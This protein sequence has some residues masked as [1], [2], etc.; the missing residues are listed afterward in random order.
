MPFRIR[1]LDAAVDVD[2]FRCGEPQLDAYIRRYASQDIRRGLT[3]VFVAT[4]EQGPQRLAGFFSLSA[5][6]VSAAILLDAM[7]R[8]LPHYPVP[9]ALLGRLAVDEGFQ[10]QGLGAVL[11]A[12]ACL[13]VAQAS[14]VLAVAGLVV[15]VKS[16]TAAAFYKHF[17]FVALPGDPGRLLLPSKAFP[18]GI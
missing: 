18:A 14:A 3:R 12:D 8:K 10:G 13:K 11:L 16:E 2:A 6:S 9:V 7:R 17:G 15:D 1:P 5:G 4:P